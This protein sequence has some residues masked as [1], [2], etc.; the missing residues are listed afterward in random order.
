MIRE[1]KAPILNRGDVLKIPLGKLMAFG[2][3]S[4]LFCLILM[5]PITAMV[6]RAVNPI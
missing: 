5:T 3:S 1:A 4:P 6:K 2:S